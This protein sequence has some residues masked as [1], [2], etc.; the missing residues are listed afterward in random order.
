MVEASG[1]RYDLKK[2]TWI[3]PCGIAG[4]GGAQVVIPQGD[5]PESP[6]IAWKY[7]VN[8]SGILHVAYV[9]DVYMYER[10]VA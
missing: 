3:W 9:K 8:F 1:S 5:L 10:K 2:M 7:A 6:I 4:G